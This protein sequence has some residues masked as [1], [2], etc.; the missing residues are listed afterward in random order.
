MKDV[1]ASRE[2]FSSQKR[3]SSTSNMKFLHFFSVFWVAFAL[4]GRIR[5]INQCGYMGIQMRIH[6]TEKITVKKI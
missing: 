4:L 2:A 6:N 5:R 1:P 3:I